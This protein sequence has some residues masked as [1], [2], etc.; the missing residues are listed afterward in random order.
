MGRKSK[1][2]R[3]RISEKKKM[4][5]K[6]IRSNACTKQ[7]IYSGKLTVSR[8]FVTC[9]NCKTRR[10]FKIKNLKKGMYYKQSKK[11]KEKHRKL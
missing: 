1:N 4:K 11:E 2:R 10:I 5:K 6:N 8:S 3:K 9:T 7:R